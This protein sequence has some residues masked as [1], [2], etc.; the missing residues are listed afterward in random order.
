MEF[1]PE[2]DDGVIVDRFSQSKK[3]RE[4][5]PVH[6]RAPMV[7]VHDS[8]W[9]IYEPTQLSDNRLVL[10]VLFYKDGVTMRAKC[11]DISLG[12]TGGPDLFVSS[13]PP[14]SSNSYLDLDVQLF[15]TA[16]PD[17]V[18]RDGRRWVEVPG[19]RL[20]R[21]FLS[22][23]F[24]NLWLSFRQADKHLI[25]TGIKRKGGGWL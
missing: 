25:L 15:S 7:H 14:F 5:I 11:L 4:E 3:W 9:Y 10:P 18:L 16:F 22:V 24:G 2:T 13:E 17:L 12:S 8:H 21:M 6:L 20:L 1:Y 23:V 19:Q